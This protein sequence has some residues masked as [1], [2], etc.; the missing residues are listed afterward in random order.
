M[1]ANTLGGLDRV[2]VKESDKAG[3]VNSVWNV[4]PFHS[5]VHLA[6]AQGCAVMSATHPSLAGM[7]NAHCAGPE[8][9]SSS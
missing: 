8:A 4:L 9:P 5:P 1:I 7:G 2:H 6:Q 3:A